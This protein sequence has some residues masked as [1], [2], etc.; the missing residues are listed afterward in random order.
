M[1]RASFLFKKNLVS[2]LCVFFT[3]IGILGTFTLFVPQIRAATEFHVDDNFTDPGE[4]T[5]GDLYFRHIQVAINMTSDGDLITV[6]PGTYVENINFN[7][8]AITVRSTNPDN[9][10]IVAATIIDGDQTGSVVTF[11][12]GE[13][14]VSRLK[15]FTIQNGHASRG[16]G[17]YCYCASPTIT[18]C[19]IRANSSFTYGFGG[20]IYCHNSSPRITNCIITNNWAYHDGGGIFCD[21]CSS[22]TITDC[23]IYDNSVGSSGG[24]IYSDH[25][26]LTITNSSISNNIAG[27]GGG[28]YCS[29]LTYPHI[30]ISNCIIDKNIAFYGGG[31]YCG[32]SSYPVIRSCTITDNRG[33][34]GGGVYCGG[35]SPNFCNSILWY[36]SSG[37]IYL[38]SGVP[39]VTYSNI[40]G[41][42]GD[43]DINHNINEDPKF[44]N[45]TSGDYH[46]QTGSPCIDKG[47]IGCAPCYDKDG[48]LRDGNPDMGAYEYVAPYIPC[49]LNEDGDV[50]NDDRNILRSALRKC[51]GDEGFVPEADYDGDGCI[52]YYDYREWYKCYKEH[53]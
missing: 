51:E 32:L 34:Y 50:D 31:I 53:L 40:Q 35:G 37:E 11:E 44:V 22:L 24:G 14:G 39:I 1:G 5:D 17:I 52:T 20:G 33:N 10:A 3:I 42:Y 21:N 41:G 25:S 4:D 9:S 15:G 43:P 13:M 19:I 46:L 18:N 47:T 26:T 36:N 2:A 27:S 12:S 8:K 6:E 29:S 49:D 16:S 30:T 38:N 28:I 7:G 23:K 45:I 48:N